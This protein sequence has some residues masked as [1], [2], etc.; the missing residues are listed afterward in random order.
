MTAVVTKGATETAGVAALSAADGP[1][2][3]AVRGEVARPLM[4][5]VINGSDIRQAVSPYLTLT[6]RCAAVGFFLFLRPT[7]ISPPRTE[8]RKE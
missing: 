8:R 5:A 2:G 7:T 6:L 4:A 1:N 3:E